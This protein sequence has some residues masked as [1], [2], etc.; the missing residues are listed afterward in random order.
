MYVV[1]A[2]LAGL[3]VMLSIN[4]PHKSRS[5]CRTSYLHQTLI[6][7]GITRGMLHCCFFIVLNINLLKKNSPGKKKALFTRRVTIV[8]DKHLNFS[9]NAIKYENAMH[10]YK[11]I[12]IMK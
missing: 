12:R 1:D 9:K 6:T 3:K 5:T 4:L 7:C 10:I 2:Q 11:S 8:Y